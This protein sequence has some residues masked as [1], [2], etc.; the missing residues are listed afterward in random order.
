MLVA[1]ELE[2]EYKELNK[3]E[4]GHMRVWDKMTATRID[5]SGTIRVVNAIPAFK[6]DAADRGKKR[7]QSL[8][9]KASQEEYKSN[10]NKQKLNIFDAQD[11]QVLK[12]ETLDRLGHDENALVPVSQSPERQSVASSVYS[13]QLSQGRKPKAIEYLNKGGQQKE[14]VRSFIDSSRKILM[15]QI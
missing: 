15:A 3:F 1:R 6:P 11:S 9:A 10:Q 5:R 12:A 13:S 8:A 7:Y 14:T 4:M 2:R